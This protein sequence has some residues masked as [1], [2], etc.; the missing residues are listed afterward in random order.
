M[1]LI[2]QRIQIP[3]RHLGRRSS[4]HRRCCYSRRQRRHHRRLRGRLRRC[5]AR[6]GCWRQRL[7]T[8]QDA[9]GTC[10]R[11]GSCGL[12]RGCLG[13][14]CLQL[15][16]REDAAAVRQLHPH[17]ACSGRGAKERAALGC[18]RSFGMHSRVCRQAR[19]PLQRCPPHLAA[20][21]VGPR[22]PAGLAWPAL[23]PSGLQP[24]VPAP[25]PPLQAGQGR[26]AGALW[27]GGSAAA[28]PSFAHRP[29]VTQAEPAFAA[30]PRQ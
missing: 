17:H 29:L 9:H 21:S 12:L 27:M 10:Q 4:C 23:P 22:A 18:V 3:R 1:Q 24:P 5:C 6:R 2:K 25:P 28:P 26:R 15:C 11:R 20:A 30:H 13:H 7:G 16:C 19:A 8:A 14:G